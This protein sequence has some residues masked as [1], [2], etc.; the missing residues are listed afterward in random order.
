MTSERSDREPGQLSGFHSPIT[1]RR[2]AAVFL[3]LCHLGLAGLTT[4]PA[5]ADLLI[6]RD[7]AQVETQGAWTVK[8]KLVVFTTPAGALT[9]VRLESVDLDASAEATAAQNAPPAPPPPPEPPRKPILVLTDADVA[10]L[11][12]E[13]LAVQRQ[14]LEAAKA[15]PAES[16]GDT[17]SGPAERLTVT[18]WNEEENNSGVTVS[19]RI[20]NVSNAVTGGIALSATFYSP[21]GERI[22]SQSAQISTTTLAPGQEAVFRVESTEFFTFSAVKFKFDSFALETG[23]DDTN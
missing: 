14:A 9:S 2:V 17:P 10:H 19:G 6:T 23:P 3:C 20:R 15:T 1:R 7:G 21:D 11:S 18:T 4:G 13:G 12:P 5:V 22:L 8:G 16:A